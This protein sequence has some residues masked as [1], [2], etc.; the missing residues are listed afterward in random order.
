MRLLLTRGF[1]PFP[2]VRKLLRARCRV[3]LDRRDLVPC[4]RKALLRLFELPLKLGKLLLCRLELFDDLRLFATP[5]FELSLNGGKLARGL[6]PSSRGL[7]RLVRCG[8]G[9]G[10]KV[11]QGPDCLLIERQPAWSPSREDVSSEIS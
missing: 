5:T 6:V 2:D 9:L 11:G 3:P 10:Q 8:L 1:Q 7:A 4:R